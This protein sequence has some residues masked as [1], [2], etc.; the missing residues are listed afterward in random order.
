MADANTEVTFEAMETAIA[1]QLAAQFPAFKTVEFYRDDEDQDIPTPALLLETVEFEPAPESD[2]GTGQWPARMRVEARVIMTKR[3][4]ATRREVRKAAL[5]LATFVHLKRW[6][7]VFAD[8]CAVIA[9]GPDE[10]A[11]NVERFSVWSVEWVQLAFFGESVWL[12]EGGVVPESFFSFVPRI[13]TPHE[14]GYER[15]DAEPRA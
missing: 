15:A 5:A 3:G 13:G 7:G 2:A 10:F 1:A 8:P 6:A 4:A 9:C 14:P 11:P 12:N